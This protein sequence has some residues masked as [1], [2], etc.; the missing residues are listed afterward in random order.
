MARQWGE[1]VLV[2]GHPYLVNSF[3]IIIPGLRLSWHCRRLLKLRYKMYA[4]RTCQ[5]VPS[6]WGTS[7]RTASRF[8]WHLHMRQQ[9]KVRHGRLLETRCRCYLP[10]YLGS[11]I[12][13]SVLRFL[14]LGFLPSQNSPV[15]WAPCTYANATCCRGSAVLNLGILQPSTCQNP[16]PGF[17]FCVDVRSELF[18]RAGS[19]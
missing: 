5:I 1:M 4:T 6:S 8:L 13:W 17:S 11:H 10:R 19:R 12:L 2:T 14:F 9:T 18:I 3:P 7:I 15:M 16:S